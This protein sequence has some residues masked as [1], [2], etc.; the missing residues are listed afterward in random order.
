MKE[1]EK[2]TQIMT[3]A[4]ALFAKYG[5]RK[6]AID[7]I[8][9]AA[10]ISKGL[11]Y[12]YYTDK[13]D[14]YVRLYE[15]YADI[16]SAAIGREVDTGERNFVTRLKQIARV[17]IAFVLQCPDLWRFLY[18]AYYERHPDVAPFIKGKN[19]ALLQGS[20]ATSAANID[21][22]GLREDVSPDRAI[23]AVTWLAEGFVRKLNEG[24]KEP[25]E[26]AYLGF[27][28]YLDL[29]WTGLCTDGRE[30]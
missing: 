21:W 19:E 17:R 25:D 7:D 9:S 10:G 14:L 29:L 5:Y 1:T 15:A 18:S 4:A 22:S 16:L 11:F 2:H 27:D 13:A 8:V 26:E 28:A 12:H 6:T 23:E 20:Y 3:A 30:E 24:E